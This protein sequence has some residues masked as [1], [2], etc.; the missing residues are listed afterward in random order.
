M[1]LLNE[2]IK[3]EMLNNTIII[4]T[5]DHGEMQGAHGLRG[6][7]GNM[8]D[9]NI[10]VPLTIF[11][12]EYTDEKRISKITSHL[13]LAP[14]IIGMR[15]NKKPLTSSAHLKGYNLMPYVSGDL[16]QNQPLRQASLFAFGMLS[17]VDSNMTFVRDPAT[18][19]VVSANIDYEKRGFVRGITTEK[20]KFARYFSPK[21]NNKPTNI[22]KLFVNNDVELFDL[23][24][25]PDEMNNLAADR[26]NN[27]ALI[28][29]LNTML[30]NLITHEI[31][32][33]SG[34]YIQTV[35]DGIEAAKPPIK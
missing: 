16:P 29:E 30:N 1:T 22:D 4:F 27:S 23:E 20:Y 33:D 25:D 21:N 26:N 5:S 8:Y 24:K 28:I 13:D 15:N 14:T 32:E 12:P 11:H 19:N 6:K 35:I 3:L 31:G 34:T 17:M 7:G 10:H 9:N 2:L 18:T